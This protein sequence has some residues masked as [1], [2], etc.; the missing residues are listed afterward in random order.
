MNKLIGIFFLFVILSSS[1]SFKDVTVYTKNDLIGQ[2]EPENHPAYSRVPDAYTTQA[3]YLRTET[4]EAFLRMQRA[5]Q[6][7][8]INLYIV[9]GTRNRARQIEIWTEKWNHVHYRRC[10]RQSRG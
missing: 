8:G 4:L 5:A 7:A 9:S 3:T 1:S 6:K 2:L 10:P